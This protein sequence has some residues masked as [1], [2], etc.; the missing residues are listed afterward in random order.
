[1]DQRLFSLLTLWLHGEMIIL[2][3]KKTNAQEFFL[4]FYHSFL[5]IVNLNEEQFG[6]LTNINRIFKKSGW[7]VWK[8]LAFFEH[9]VRIFLPRWLWKCGI[10]L[11]LVAKCMCKV[12][13]GLQWT[14]FFY[15]FFLF[16]HLR[17]HTN[18]SKN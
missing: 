13:I 12:A 2:P 4:Y 7:R 9:R 3:L 6:L 15:F 10:I 14:F 18:S 5:V 16:P 8:A 1:M 17:F 11:F